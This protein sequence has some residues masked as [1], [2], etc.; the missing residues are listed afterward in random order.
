MSLAEIGKA[1]TTIEVGRL[2]RFTAA[3]FVTVLVTKGVLPEAAQ[4]PVIDAVS[5]VGSTL[6]MYIWSVIHDQRSGVDVEG[7]QLGKGKQ[8]RSIPDSGAVGATGAEAVVEETA[9]EGRREG[10]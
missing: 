7:I 9:E 3:P 8:A 1:A 4:G 2:I 6:V 5:I 10:T